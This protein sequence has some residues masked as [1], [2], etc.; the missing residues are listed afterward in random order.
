V[1]KDKE[2]FVKKEKEDKQRVKKE[3]KEREVM[4]F[5]ENL[6]IIKN[7]LKGKITRKIPKP[8]GVYWLKTFPLSMVKN[9]LIDDRIFE[10]VDYTQSAGKYV[11]EFDWL[12][13]DGLTIWGSP[14]LE[15]EEMLTTESWDEVE[16]FITKYDVDLFK[17]V[18]NHNHL[19]NHEDVN[20]I[21]IYSRENKGVLHSGY[22]LLIG[23]VP[24]DLI[25]K[26]YI[27]KESCTLREFILDKS[28]GKKTIVFYETTENLKRL[29]VMVRDYKVSKEDEYPDSDP[30][31]YFNEKDIWD[32]LKNKLL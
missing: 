9:T 15:E 32:H 30:Y 16:L 7:L 3:K 18:N 26:P 27:Y 21:Y 4:S 31:Y 6:K 28:L 23:G 5:K 25:G 20:F 11:E 2:E 1:K 17:T 12:L 29:N 10:C 8:I 13:F 19:H 24:L 14:I 22:K